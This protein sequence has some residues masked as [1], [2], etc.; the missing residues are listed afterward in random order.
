MHT[1]GSILSLAA[2]LGALLAPGR[3]AGAPFFIQGPGVTLSGFRIT[4]VASGLSYRLGMVQLS[5]G[6]LPVGVSDGSSFDNST[7]DLIRVI[8]TN[9]DG[10]ADCPGE[11]LYGGL[12]G[13]KLQFASV[14]S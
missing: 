5:D 9:Q 1:V 14:D 2:T 6:S 4:A 8:E 10:V 3:S 13:G 7:G 11:L 12:P